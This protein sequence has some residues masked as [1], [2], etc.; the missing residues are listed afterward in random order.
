MEEKG[1]GLVEE[2][3]DEYDV[4]EEVEDVIEELLAGL[5]DR[6]T[7]VRWTAAKG[8]FLLNHL[9]KIDKYISAETATQVYLLLL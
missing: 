3:D 1:D 4:P 7:V 2:M 6:E 9:N 5:R 8:I